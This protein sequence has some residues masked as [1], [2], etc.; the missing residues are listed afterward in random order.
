MARGLIGYLQH[1]ELGPWDA[2]S[3][4]L[5]ACFGHRARLTACK[6]IPAARLC[7]NVGIGRFC[8]ALLAGCSGG[9]QAGK[10][11]RWELN[12]QATNHHFYVSFF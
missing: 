11:S 7:G 1:V 12:K 5:V 4:S 9:Q 10:K 2:G 6:L 8:W 3:A